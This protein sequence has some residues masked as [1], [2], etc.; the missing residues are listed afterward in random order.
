MLGA[1]AVDH[2][3]EGVTVW[4]SGSDFGHW[5]SIQRW[6]RSSRDQSS[7]TPHH[8]E[9][10]ARDLFE[11]PTIDLGTITGGEAVKSVPQSARAEIDIRSTAGVDTRD[12]LS[13]IRA[14][15]ADCYGRG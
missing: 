6:S 4:E 5:T 13:D 11:C 2:L 9:T 1:N 10:A 7:T 14:C 15:V 3:Y 8:G 12:V